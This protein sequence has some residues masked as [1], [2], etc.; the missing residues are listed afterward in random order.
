MENENTGKR[1]AEEERKQS[2]DFREAKCCPSAVVQRAARK[3]KVCMRGVLRVT[4]THGKDNSYF[5]P[6]QTESLTTPSH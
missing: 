3:K 2:T 1:E 6:T 4:G 5:D